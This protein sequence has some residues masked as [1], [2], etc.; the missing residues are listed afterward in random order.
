MGFLR[1]AWSACRSVQ[2]ID[3]TMERHTDATTRDLLTAVCRP[4]AHFHHSPAQSRTLFHLG[5]RI[6]DG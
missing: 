6:A 4:Y 1:D 3:V 5:S 2:R